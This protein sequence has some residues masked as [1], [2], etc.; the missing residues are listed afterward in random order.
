MSNR[1][2]SNITRVTRE[3]LR[4]YSS[5]T[6]FTPGISQSSTPQIIVVTCSA[7]VGNNLATTASLSGYFVI[8]I[9]SQS[10][11]QAVVANRGEVNL[12]IF[13]VTSSLYDLQNNEGAFS[14]SITGSASYYEPIS[15]DFLTNINIPVRI[16]KNETALNVAQKTYNE[17]RTNANALLYVSSS[18]SASTIQFSSIISGANNNNVVISA[19]GFTYNYIQS[20]SFGNGLVYGYKAAKGDLLESSA[21]FSIIRDSSTPNDVKIQR[22]I[23][24]GV[25][26]MLYLSG[27]GK[28]GIRTD[29]PETD[30]DIRANTFQVQRESERRGIKVNPEGN[31]ES[32]DKNVATATTGS[33][34]ILKYSRGVA[35]TETMMEAIAVAKL[36]LLTVSEVRAGVETAFN[37]LSNDSQLLI[38]EK[39]EENGFINP[40]QVG[41][42]L[43]QLRW[44]AESGSIG[45]FHPRTTGETAAIKAK[46]ADVDNTGI[47][48]NLEF[49]ISPNKNS[50]A[51]SVLTLDGGLN[52]TVTGSL[53]FKDELI[54]IDG[55]N[56]DIDTDTVKAHDNSNT[57]VDFNTNQL[58]FH[59]NSATATVQIASNALTVNPSKTNFM[60]FNV[61]GDNDDNL[62]FGDAASDK[63]GIGTSSPSE[64]L[65]VTGNISASGNIIGTVDG[66]SF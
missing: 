42:T 47:T 27:S 5:G 35:I 4:M 55:S 1:L 59:A 10:I 7:D 34:Y 46:V 11:T 22:N 65:T 61:K 57:K 58:N 30:V 17:L 62:V 37:N 28:L 43:G 64:K 54:K 9:L 56:G 21:S 2:N 6:L 25:I 66:G 26:S 39:A 51:T 12:N 52:H 38:L 15:Q 40:P 63:V 31:I 3:G 45:D 19:S 41:D 20:G 29:S 48:S 53:T 36:G 33:E 60:D 44:V 32:F 8:P 23:P 14:G 18:I 16:L 49:H 24:T 50:S 13:Y